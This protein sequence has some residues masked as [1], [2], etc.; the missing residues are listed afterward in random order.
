MS[1]SHDA[2]WSI[3]MLDFGTLDDV[4]YESSVPLLRP[5]YKRGEQVMADN[6][7]VSEPGKPLLRVP[8]TDLVPG[9]DVDKTPRCQRDGKFMKYNAANDRMEC[10]NEGCGGFAI[11]NRTFTDAAGAELLNPPAIYRGALQ[12]IVDA[13][14]EMYLY[15]PD[16]NAAVSLMGLAESEPFKDNPE[17]NRQQMKLMNGIATLFPEA[18]RAAEKLKRDVR[19]SEEVTEMIRKHDQQMEE[20]KNNVARV[21]GIPLPPHLGKDS[22]DALSRWIV[23]NEPHKLRGMP[24]SQRVQLAIE[25]FEP[26]RSAPGEIT[27]V[28]RDEHGV[29]QSRSIFPTAYRDKFYDMVFRWFSRQGAEESWYVMLDG[30]M[31]TH[32]DLIQRHENAEQTTVLVFDKHG[33]IKRVIDPI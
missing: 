13:D 3:R 33:T 28:L 4:K 8:L 9:D 10:P 31:Y 30:C 24:I 11:R 6:E 22:T 15:L 27:L 1:E 14:G 32:S 7:T 19:R 29:Q 2:N 5:R 23:E 26:T 25:W 12:F 21:M 18:V 17:A 16:A 20:R